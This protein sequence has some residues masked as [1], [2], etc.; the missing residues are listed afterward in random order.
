MNWNTLKWNIKI[1]EAS[2]ENAK[3]DFEKSIVSS[4]NEI[5]TYYK[6][7]Q[8]ANFSYALQDKNLKFQKEITKHY[9]NRYNIGNVEFKNCLKALINEKGSE[10]NLLKVKFDIIQDENKLYQTMAGKIK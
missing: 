1:D 4:L 8:K 3:V 5:D 7:Y 10:L 9:K 6:S 2:Y